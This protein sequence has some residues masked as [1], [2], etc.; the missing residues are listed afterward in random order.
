MKRGTWVL[1]A[2]VAALVAVILLWERKLPGTAEVEKEKGRLLPVAVKEARSLARTGW[3]PVALAKHDEERWDL[4]LPVADRADRYAVTGFLDRLADTEVSRWVEGALPADLGL[5]A[6]RASWTLELPAGK[7]TVELGGAAPLEAGIYLRVDGRVALVPPSL[8][9][10]LLRP[11]SDF[12]A[13]ELLTVGSPDVDSL[14][15]REGGRERL[16]FRRE[17]EG[18]SVSAP[19]S[20]DGDPAGLESLL[21]DVC[22]CPLNSVVEDNPRDLS[23]YGLATPIQEIR[24][25]TKK[26]E[27]VLRL[28]SAVPGSDPAK[29]LL[30][31]S[32]SDRPASVFSISRNSLK[33]LSG[34]FAS[35]RSLS[36]F[37]RDP[38]E[39]TSLTLSGAFSLTLAS[40]K[41][42]GWL[43][44]SPPPGAKA[45][46]G[47]PLF[48][49]IAGLKGR[50]AQPAGDLAAAGLSP[51]YL[52]LVLKGEGWEEKVEVGAEENGRRSLRRTGRPILLEVGKEDWQTLEAALTVA[53]GK[54]PSA[55]PASAPTKP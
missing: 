11:V 6:P 23:R 24:L 2:V 34:D 48:S 53:S 46:D 41:Q 9:E 22:A 25:G 42:G 1:L 7:T 15:Y 47:A 33:S 36:P 43:T 21:D 10:T 28:G 20:D 49:A 50:R 3:A 40:D 16:S 30:Y 45:G 12:R 27:V 5:D 32:T 52:T 19:F 35:L 38:Y 14:Q 39:A 29:A 51:P 31:A 13:K 55:T 4:T 54:V 17:G 18:W 44:Q 8:E 26:G 37:R